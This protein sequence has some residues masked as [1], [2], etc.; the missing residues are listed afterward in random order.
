MQGHVREQKS[1]TTFSTSSDCARGRGGFQAPWFIARLGGWTDTDGERQ[2]QH[3]DFFSLPLITAQ[4]TMYAQPLLFVGG[5]FLFGLVFMYL[6]KKHNLKGTNQECMPW[7]CYLEASK[8]YFKLTGIW[9]LAIRQET[10]ASLQARA[11]SVRTITILWESAMHT[12]KK[13]F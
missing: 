3:Q 1:F 10:D 8:S 9:M 13:H 11:I 12:R 2:I 4:N 5:V 6:H 7:I